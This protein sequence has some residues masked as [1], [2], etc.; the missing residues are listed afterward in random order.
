M[1]DLSDIG[2]PE[3]EAINALRRVQQFDIKSLV[4]AE[5]LGQKLALT[6]LV[7][8]LKEVQ[9]LFLLLPPEYL[10]FF[11]HNQRES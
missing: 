2:D 5:E 8:P 4:R 1:V 10:A 9:S 6:E 3:K 7:E 11:P